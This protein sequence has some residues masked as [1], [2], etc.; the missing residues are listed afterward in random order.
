[1]LGRGVIHVHTDILVDAFLRFMVHTVKSLDVF[2]TCYW[3]ELSLFFVASKF[4]LGLRKKCV[5]DNR[6][7]TFKVYWSHS[8]CH[9]FY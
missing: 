5:F 4:P 7:I 8:L 2:G 3:A 6:Y 1:M 9:C